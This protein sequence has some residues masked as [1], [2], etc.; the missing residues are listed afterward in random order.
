MKR[1]TTFFLP[2]AL[3]LGSLAL[4]TRKVLKWDPVEMRVTNAPETEAWL[5]GTYRKGWELPA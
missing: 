1:K 5:Q 3:L 2:L 4:R